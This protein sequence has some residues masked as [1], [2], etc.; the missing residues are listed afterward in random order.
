MRAGGATATFTQQ[1]NAPAGR[2]DIAIVRNSDPTGV[3]ALAMLSEDEFNRRLQVLD[4][5][6]RRVEAIKES[7]MTKGTD[8]GLIPGTGQKPTLLKPGAEK[9][10]EFYRLAAEIR[11]HEKHGDGTS[12]PLIGYVAE[13][14]LHLGTTDGPVV[15]VG[16]GVCTNWEKKYRYRGSGSN[17]TEATDP[18]EQANTIAKMAEKRAFVDAVLRATA[19]SSLFTQD[20]EDLYADQQ[21]TPDTAPG[22]TD[23]APQRAAQGLAADTADGAVCPVHNRAWRSNSRGF[24]CSGKMANGDWCD[25]KPSKAWVAAQELQ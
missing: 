6:R 13:C 18:W 11:L 9:L 5:G 1:V 4:Q 25:E 2:I 21:A 3:A 12:T 8:Y 20:L 10:A 16:W 15:A 14:L 24:Y 23:N 22:G 7:L 19:S 17:R